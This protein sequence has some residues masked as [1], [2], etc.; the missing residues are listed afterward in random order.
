MT[1]EELTPAQIRQSSASRRDKRRAIFS[2]HRARLAKSSSKGLANKENVRCARFVRGGHMT[3]AS[4]LPGAFPKP[5]EANR[6][7]ARAS[8]S[9]GSAPNSR[10]GGTRDLVARDV[11]LVSGRCDGDGARDRPGGRVHVPE[12]DC[13][14]PVRRWPGARYL[15]AISRTFL[16]HG[17]DQAAHRGHALE[18]G[19]PHH[20]V[21]DGL[22]NLGHREAR[23]AHPDERREAADVARHGGAADEHVAV[24]GAVD[25]ILV[26]GAATSTDSAPKHD[27]L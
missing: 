11:G 26:P 19:V 15:D 20:R 16:A 7:R 14:R 3:D 6:T 27:K 12:G 10:G 24:A 25:K 9:T 4:V 1:G 18:P 17:V 13:P 21:Q 22:L 23:P 5:L 2:S 8:H